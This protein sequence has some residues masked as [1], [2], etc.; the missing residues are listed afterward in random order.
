[1]KHQDYTIG[2]ICALSV[3]YIAACELLDEEHPSLPNVSFHDNNAYTLG[4]VGEHN[5]VIACLPMGQYG[6]TSAAAMAKDI[7]RSFESVRIGL[8]VGI[9][10][11]A[12][13]KKHDIRL[14]D[15]VV[16]SPVGKTGGVIQY[17][18]G[19]TIQNGKFQQTGSLNSPPT[20]LLTA[21]NK[22]LA[23]HRR[24]GHRI[25]ESVLAMAIKNPRIK[26][27]FEYPGME[28]D[29]LYEATYIHTDIDQNCGEVCSTA[30][31]PL[32]RRDPR[33]QDQDNPAVHYGLIA[34][35]DTLMKDAEVRDILIKEQDVL[36]F[37]MEAAGLMQNF[38]CV[39]IRGICD[40]SDS[41]KNDLW[42]GYAAATAAVYAKELL[43]NIPGAEVIKHRLAV[44]EIG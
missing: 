15:I 39:V 7:L 25:A 10:G 5:V 4:R 6:T 12:P 41:H 31:P 22:I 26:K 11:G 34:S 8:M 28:N 2:W 38:P 1:M 9:G 14:G 13:S 37:E 33:D 36:C 21:L 44:E 18:F 19:K 32:L 16:S 3:E 17:M 24:K 23:I 40:Y 43:L 35:A 20:V 30:V 29:R 42:Q 27:E